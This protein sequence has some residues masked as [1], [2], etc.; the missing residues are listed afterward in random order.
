[1]ENVKNRQAYFLSI[2]AYCMSESEVK[3]FDGRIDGSIIH[4][5]RG[6]KG[7]GFDPI[8][9]PKEGDGKTFAEMSTEA[10]SMLSHRGNS[11]R[12]LALWIKQKKG[13]KVKG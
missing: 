12:K 3:I 2:I 8:F 10:K 11:F 6:K 5:K 7:F 9:C 1:M 13:K 4:E